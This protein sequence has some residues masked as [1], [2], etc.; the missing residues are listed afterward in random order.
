MALPTG[1][2]P[3]PGSDLTL[4]LSIPGEPVAPPRPHSMKLALRLSLATLIVSSAL[5][6]IRPSAVMLRYPDVSAAHIAFRFDGDLWLCL[7]YTSPS[8][9]D[10]RG[11]RMPSSA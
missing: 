7:L 9:R 2:A 6:Q 11:S 3:K 1:S 10:Q 8:P 4:W 5:G